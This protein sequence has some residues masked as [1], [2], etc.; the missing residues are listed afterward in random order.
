MKELLKE[1]HISIKQFAELWSHAKQGRITNQIWED[2]DL[3]T[4]NGLL[5]CTGYPELAALL[6]K[7]YPS[8]ATNIALWQIPSQYQLEVVRSIKDEIVGPNGIEYVKA[9]ISA[10]SEI[11]LQVIR[12]VGVS[13][14]PTFLNAYVQSENSEPT[15]L[16]PLL[17]EYYNEFKLWIKQQNPRNLNDKLFEAIFI[18]LNY[19]KLQRL[20]ISS[21]M[22]IVG[23]RS[24]TRKNSKVNEI[25]AACIVLSIGFQNRIRHAEY[26]VIETFYTVYRFGLN[27]Q[28]STSIWQ[29]INRDDYHYQD[30]A[31]SVGFWSMF[32]KK[33][34]DRV[35]SW[36]YCESL[37]RIGAN[38]FVKNE[39]RSQSFAL[40]FND[41]KVFERV[42]DYL[43]TYDK[44]HK[45]LNR[46]TFEAENGRLKL[47][48]FQK[49]I[50]NSA[51][52]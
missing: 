3:S 30:E 2:I 51:F 9:L 36:D 33:K 31:E 42:I 17:N 44:G 16:Q 8:I 26:L 7:R 37:I 41:P 46:L 52:E 49:G 47:S 34:K 1:G 14:L 23:Y 11:L 43:I 21:D 50:L 38:S 22:W 15:Y 5:L 6:I 20:D 27:Q 32:T 13:S 19:E 25:F 39:W 18:S 12:H 45:Y 28:L 40:T 24:V 10:R 4:E 48:K 35:P 29:M